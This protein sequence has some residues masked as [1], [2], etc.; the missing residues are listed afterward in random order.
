MSALLELTEVSLT[1][2]RRPILDRVSASLRAGE[3]LGILGENGVGKSTL[4]SVMAGIA[5]PVSG[6]V[7]LMGKPLVSHALRTR[8]AI[9]S[10]L[11]Q[12]MECYWP[13]P[14][15]RVVAL[16]RLPHLAPL[17]TLSRLD[18][19]QVEHTLMLTDT[20]HLRHRK[21]TELSGG[22]RA[23]VLLARALASAPK[24]LLADEPVSSLDAHHQLTVMQR[25]ADSAQEGMAVAVVLH[26]LSLAARFCDRILLLHQ[27]RVLADG[28]A[29]DVLSD[30]TLEIA[31]KVRVAR[32]LVQDRY[33]PLPVTPITN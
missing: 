23:R 32:P 12:G 11:P 27:G 25:L 26:D 2:K 29:A 9:L 16:G 24:I 7:Q 6:T 18:R 31:L 22:E 8:A 1:R 4:L 13:L 14:V 15:E 17:Q 20:L 28:A 3:V 10:Y 30:E 21:V 19:E 5:F 33:V